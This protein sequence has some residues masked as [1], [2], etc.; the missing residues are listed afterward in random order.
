M[1]RACGSDILEQVVPCVFPAQ[2]GVLYPEELSWR[3][4]GVGGGG[5]DWTCCGAVVS[6]SS[7]LVQSL[8]VY[9]GPLATAV[10]QG[11]GCLWLSNQESER[12]HI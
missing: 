5:V 2:L 11:H 12:T 9:G 4:Y 3:G 6:S 10:A 8:G 1:G 7:F